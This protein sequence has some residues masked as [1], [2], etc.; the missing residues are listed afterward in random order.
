[1]QNMKNMQNM[2]NLHTEFA[3]QELINVSIASRQKFGQDSLK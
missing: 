2:Q 3:G 1:M